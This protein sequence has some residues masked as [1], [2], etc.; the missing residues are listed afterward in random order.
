M[1]TKPTINRVMLVYPNQRWHKYDLTTTWNLSPYI[2]C[3]LAAML[4]NKYELKIV[5]AQFY[6]MTEKQFEKEVRNFKPDCVGISILSSE[7]ASILDT[8]AAIVKEI[9]KD[10]VTIS[11]G[12]HVTTQ[13][14]RV[15]ENKDIDYAVRGEGEYVLRDF[16]AYLN[17]EGTFPEKGIVFQNENG[18]VTAL[19]PHIVQDLY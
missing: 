2:L 15:L 6:N 12:V 3:L 13:Y 7:Y 19:P 17:S 8:A 10:I 5:D 1:N 4:R 9:N 18:G 16:L 14:Y 11:G